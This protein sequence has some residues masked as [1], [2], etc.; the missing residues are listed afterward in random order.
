MGKTITTKLE[1]FNRYYFDKDTTVQ[2]LNFL[3]ER[4]T[5]VAPHKKGDVSFSY[6]VVKNAEDVVLQYPRTIQPL[7]KMFLPPREVLLNFNIKKNTFTQQ[8]P[9]LE[10]RIF[11][12]IHSY[13]MQSVK[14]LDYSFTKGNPESNYL[15]RRENSLFIGVAFEPDKWHFSSAVGIDIE[16]TDGFALYFYPLGP[17][18]L[19]F[20]ITEQGSNLIKEFGL[21]TLVNDQELEIEQIEFQSKIKYHY[22]RL[23]EIFKHVYNSKVWED[24]AQR[25]VGCGTCNLLCPTCYCFDVRDEIELDAENGH[26]ARTWDGCMLNSFAE[27][28]GGENFRENLGSRTRHRLHRKFK[29]IT[30]QSGVLHCVG[31]GRCSRYCPADISLVEIVNDLIDDYS[32]QQKKEAI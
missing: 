26:R 31:C 24:V 16:E 8:E 18:Y 29:Y 12:G 27:V 7:K 2:F 9:K 13:E 17:G 3:M 19:V 15:A 22:N 6:Q 23:P 10:K 32:D 21:G 25:C 11:F 14:R 20:E 1:V 4:S 5:V 30:E 28:A